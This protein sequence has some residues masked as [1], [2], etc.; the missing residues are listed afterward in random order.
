[1]S[2]IQ[3]DSEMLA[4]Y[5]QALGGYIN[6]S[7]KVTETLREVK[8]SLD[9]LRNAKEHKYLYEL[10]K[11][12]E[13]LNILVKH[14]EKVGMP[15]IDMYEE[16]IARI[17]PLLDSPDWP[18]AVDPDYLIESEDGKK[19]RAQQILD[20]V[21]PEHL[22]GTKFLDYGCG[23]GHV[24]AE[25]SQRG[26]AQSLGYDIEKQWGNES[27]LTTDFAIV[28]QNAPWDIVLLYDVLDHCKNPTIDLGKILEILSP[29]GKV[30]VRTHPWCGKHGGHLFKTIN[31][32]YVHVL[33]D[34]V[35]QMRLFG[36]STPFVLKFTNPR[37]VYHEWFDKAGF[38]VVQESPIKD[39]QLHPFFLNM[40]NI[41]I[42]ERIANHW[43]GVDPSKDM[44]LNFVNYTLEPKP[45][46]QQ[47][48]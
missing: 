3:F 25:A 47:V 31:K 45:S 13:D 27:N 46:H 5:S 18:A 24:V 12:Q 39:K 15:G 22:E 37:G 30:Y 35:E 1:M 7:V 28:K 29:T 48:L 36:A 23:E 21:V 34:E 14:L 41:H 42:Q 43:R 16:K 19:V 40:D 2:D 4:S 44:T 10:R 20:F 9:E 6:Q 32:A 33:F 11:T 17:K 26:T 38:K 8:Q